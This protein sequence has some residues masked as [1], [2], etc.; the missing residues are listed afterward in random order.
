MYKVLTA[1]DEA[2]LRAALAQLI[3][4][5]GMDCEVVFEACDGFEALEYMR[6]HPVDIAIL[7]IRMPGLTGLELCAHMHQEGLEAAVIVLTAYSDF[8]LVRDALREG[9]YDYV[10]KSAFEVE[11]PSALGKAICRL[12]KKA[13]PPV[14]P[15][16]IEY[17][18]TV[19]Q[20]V[21]YLREHY[22][23][24]V[25][26]S[27]I[28]DRL[29]L[30]QSYLCRRYKQETGSTILADLIQLRIGRAKE[31]LERGCTVAQAANETGFDSAAHFSNVFT[32]YEH[33][34]PGNYRKIHHK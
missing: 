14:E 4:W 28:A 19:D 21:E 26:V 3:D 9:V 1:D 8:A 16:A 31:L 5:K 24:K 33:V 23:E 32:R 13:E 17:S 12:P 25:K 15:P 2:P 34:S 30:N 20:V 7:D 10:I 6:S 27:D 18:Q 11:L 22:A 29:Y